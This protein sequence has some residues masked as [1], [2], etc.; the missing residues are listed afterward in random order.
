[1]NI[2]YIMM[3]LFVLM[4]FISGRLPS[5]ENE[6]MMLKNGEEEKAA[7]DA[8]K[9]SGIDE[10]SARVDSGTRNLTR[11]IRRWIACATP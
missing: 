7:T 3:G 4:L 2:S 9:E 8:A 10:R 5:E 11:W 1:M 6:R